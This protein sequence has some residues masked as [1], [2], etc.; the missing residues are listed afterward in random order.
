MSLKPD[1]ATMTSQQLQAYI[2]EHRN[3]QE[4]LQVYLDRRHSEN[5]NAQVYRAEDDVSKAIAEY[6]ENKKQEAS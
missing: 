3:D 6:W 2:L 5:P 1:F 4:A